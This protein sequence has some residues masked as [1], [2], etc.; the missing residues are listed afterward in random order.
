M[1]KLICVCLTVFVLLS[2]TGCCITLPLQE[3]FGQKPL[4]PSQ[5]QNGIP[6]GDYAISS[7]GK[8][9][10]VTF[11]TTVDPDNGY[12]KMKSDGTGVFHFADS[13]Y[14]FEFRGEELYV[15]GQL[16][17]W[18]YLGS[19]NERMLMLFWYT[20]DAD[21]IILRPVEAN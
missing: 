19:E 6:A 1:K 13:E 21:S 7:I 20:E 14:S 16:M 17:V 8:D 11:M 3:V 2:F 5:K 9:G 15:N 10:N 18:N 12:L 4:M